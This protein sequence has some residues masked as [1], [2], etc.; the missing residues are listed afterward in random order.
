MVLADT[1]NKAPVFADQDPDM[2][3]D[4]TDQ[5][6][7]VAENT[8]SLGAC[9]T[10]GDPARSSYGLHHSERRNDNRRRH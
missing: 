5:E 1:R 4:Q 2:E 9:S 6:R 3:G 10:I 7:T 8:P